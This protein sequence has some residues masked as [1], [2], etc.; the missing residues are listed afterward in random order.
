MKYITI[1]LLL[2]LVLAYNA[3]VQQN[4]QSSEELSNNSP[5][6]EEQSFDSQ[7]LEENLSLAKQQ[8]LESQRNETSPIRKLVKRQIA[9]W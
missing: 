3:Q 9:C 1:V 5:S 4:S 6:S 7:S 2:G 8:A